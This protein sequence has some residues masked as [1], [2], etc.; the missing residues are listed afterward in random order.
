M[1][2][3]EKEESLVFSLNAKGIAL[4]QAGKFKE[5][6]AAFDKAIE[7]DPKLAGLYFNRAEARRLSGDTKAARADLEQALGIAPKDPEFLHALGLV[8]YEEEDFAAATE[9]YR[10]ALEADPGLAKAW[11]DLGVVNFRKGAFTEA[12]TCFEKAV[13]EDKDMAEA[14]FNLADT[15]D[16]LGLKAQRRTALE[17]LKRHE[18]R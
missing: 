17:E 11:N 1:Q 15:Y 14:W 5:A 16:E 4:T 2:V 10:R 9:F 8:S 12:R 13:A 18:Q 3:P 7:T 6:A